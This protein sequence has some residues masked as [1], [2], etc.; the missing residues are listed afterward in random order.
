MTLHCYKIKENYSYTLCLSKD[1][2][3]SIVE[4]GLWI[5]DEILDEEQRTETDKGEFFYL[6]YLDIEKKDFQKMYRL[7]SDLPTVKEGGWA[8]E[9]SI[10]FTF[11]KLF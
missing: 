10:P 4:D 6:S 9:K 11:Q 7:K 3:K 8:N 1:K 5:I 2:R